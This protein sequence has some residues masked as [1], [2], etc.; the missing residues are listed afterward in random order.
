MCS[1]KSETVSLHSMRCNKV[2]EDKN[3][4]IKKKFKLIALIS[5]WENADACDDVREFCSH[6][7]GRWKYFRT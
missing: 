3:H 7:Q 5:D 4:C 2:V 1:D 6:Q